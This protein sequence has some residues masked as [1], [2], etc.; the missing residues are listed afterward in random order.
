MAIRSYRPDDLDAVYEIC[1]RT[2]DAGSDASHLVSD[3]D[4]PGHV[5]AGP[6]LALCPELAFVLD[7]DGAVAGYVI[8]ALDTRAFVDAYRE[9]WLPRLTS[10]HPPPVAPPA[11]HEERLLDVLHRPELLLTP[12]FPEHPSHLHVNLLPG[13]QGRGQGRALVETIC[14]ALRAAGSPGIHLG[15]QRRNE[16][17]VG[18]YARAGFEQLHDDADAVFFGRALRGD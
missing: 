1:L 16:R 14:D 5:Y 12:S 2:G 4:L 7:D 18:F 11:T 6:Y 15:V 9:R 17:A 3:P 10:S 13:A 8:G